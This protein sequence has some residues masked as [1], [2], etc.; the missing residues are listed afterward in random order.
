[1]R[2][3]FKSYTALLGR[4]RSAVHDLRRRRSQPRSKGPRTKMEFLDL[5]LFQV[6]IRL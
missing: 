2:T 5:E 6:D 1:M 4:A 3:A